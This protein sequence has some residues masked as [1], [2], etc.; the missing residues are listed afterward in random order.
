MAIYHF[1]LYITYVI[2]LYMYIVYVCA[3][4]SFIACIC[5]ISVSC[6]TAC[7]YIGCSCS[8]L[9]YGDSVPQNILCITIYR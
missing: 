3:N 4:H 7:I 1:H 9:V 5:T 8:L 6:I 2:L